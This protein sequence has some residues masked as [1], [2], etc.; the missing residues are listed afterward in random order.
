[1]E[2]ITDLN[3]IFNY[4]VLDVRVEVDEAV[5]CLHFDVDDGEVA[6]QLMC[7]GYAGVDWTD[8][9]L[10]PIDGTFRGNLIVP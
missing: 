5:I 1:M 10:N 6:W 8:L 7:V 4:T 2:V 9:D 3:E